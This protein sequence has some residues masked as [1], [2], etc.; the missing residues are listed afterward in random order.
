MGGQLG[1]EHSI[2]TFLQPGGFLVP[3][4]RIKVNKSMY[5]QQ[6]SMLIAH[7]LKSDRVY[8]LHFANNQLYE[9]VAVVDDLGHN[10]GDIQVVCLPERPYEIFVLYSAPLDPGAVN[11]VIKDRHPDWYRTHDARIKPMPGREQFNPTYHNISVEDIVRSSA[12]N[13]E[14]LDRKDED[15]LDELLYSNDADYAKSHF[16]LPICKNPGS[17][18]PH[19]TTALYAETEDGRVL[20]GGMPLYCNVFEEDTSSKFLWAQGI[21]NQLDKDEGQV[22]GNIVWLGSEDHDEMEDLLHCKYETKDT[23]TVERCSTHHDPSVPVM[24]QPPPPCDPASIPR[25]AVW[26]LPQVVLNRHGCPKLNATGGY[27]W[28]DTEDFAARGW[29]YNPNI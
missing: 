14:S 21:P 18:T 1:N 29:L 9:G 17:A 22:E 11:G 6:L 12:R 28:F 27:I 8:L 19:Y 16:S 3:I 5:Q 13:W 25:D 24:M 4:D 10:I 26:E 7:I 2:E 20:P 15:L 23:K